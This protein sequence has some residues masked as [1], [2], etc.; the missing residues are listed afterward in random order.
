MRKKQPTA[1]PE[2]KIDALQKQVDELKALLGEA[3]KKLSTKAA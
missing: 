2:E 1:R 3:M